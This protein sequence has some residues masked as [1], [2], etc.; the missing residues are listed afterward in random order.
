MKLTSRAFLLAACVAGATAIGFVAPSGDALA[1]DEANQND[2]DHDVGVEHGGDAHGE[3]HHGFNFAYGLLGEGDADI[4]PNLW[5]RPKGMPVPFLAMLINSTILFGGLYLL[6]RKG[7][8]DALSSRRQ[9]IIQGMEDA[10]KMRREATAQLAMYEQKLREVEADVERVK[11]EMREAAEAE[12]AHI[13]SDAKA[14]RERM[15]RD[16]RL[17]I[18]QELDAAHEELR[19]ATVRGAIESAT[20][21]LRQRV[22]AEDQRRF[23]REYLS[24]LSGGFSGM[25][26]GGSTRGQA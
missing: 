17:L 15:E 11:R 26:R 3:G 8:R 4:E 25:A 21:L 19:K 24:S 1:A 12:R 23:E 14:R 20:E 5:F 13:L 9:R 6:G 7:M 10:A 2:E 22:G 18:Q 16:A